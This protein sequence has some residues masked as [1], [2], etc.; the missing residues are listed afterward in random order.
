MGT[1]DRPAK[2]DVGAMV[3]VG[4]TTPETLELVE[5]KAKVSAAPNA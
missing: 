3:T 1:L 4:L 2:L 5:L